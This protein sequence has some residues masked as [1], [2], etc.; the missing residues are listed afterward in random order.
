MLT[1]PPDPLPEFK[2]GEKNKILHRE[3]GEKEL[4]I[5]IKRERQL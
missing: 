3:R 5:R 1:P 2:E 4:A